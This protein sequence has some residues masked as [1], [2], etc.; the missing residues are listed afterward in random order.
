MSTFTYSDLIALD[1]GKLN[2]AVTDWKTTVGDLAKLRTDVYDTLVAKSDAAKWKGVN[3]TVTKDFVRSTAKE[4]LDLHAEAESIYNVLRDAHD[5]LTQ[6]QKQAKA[7][8]D[9]A[10]RG[11]PER[12]P[13]PDPGLLVTDGGNGTVKVMEAMCD[14]KGTSQR[15]KDM[16]QWY[17]DALTGLVS[18]ASEVD[19]AVTRALKRSHGGDPHNAGHATYT[20]LDEDQ[21]PRAM[22]LASL[23]GDAN[24]K[25]HAELRRL[26]Q[27]LSPDG[28]AEL[29]R[30]QK[31]D[32]LATGIL[33]PTAKQVAPDRGSG[34]HAAEKAGWDEFMTQEKMKLLVQGADV[35]GMSDASRHMAHYLEGS[36]EPMDLPVD[37]MMSDDKG[38]RSHIDRQIVDAQG[39]WREQALE[40]FR[41]NGGRPV[42]I[43]VETKSADYS[44]Q[45]DTDENWYFA[46]GS[47]RANVTGVVTVVPD[48]SG[49]PVVGL[50]YQANTWDRY[51][52]DEGKGVTIGPID[53]PDG[54]MGRMHTTGLANEFDMGGSSTVKHYDL[55][56]ATPNDTSPPQPDDP[57]RDGGRTDP[58]REQQKRHGSLLR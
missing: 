49:Q 35:Q 12:S 41:K 57:G 32:L 51:N 43:P 22:K 53:I 39:E 31:E 34:R 3:A 38:F 1:L 9:E 6:I 21:L 33:N 44:F 30:G 28:R 55:G 7:L 48:A 52:W 45:Q 17:A 46:V 58:G 50:D 27:S 54:Q 15:T 11:A 36:G 42:S 47:A 10:R 56:G 19:A 37:K 4:F 23:G 14:A 29:W 8:T 24:D 2:A 13:E 5:E 40:E 20:S 16:M 25:Q 26:W 18:H